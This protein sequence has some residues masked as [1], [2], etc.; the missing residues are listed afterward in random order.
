MGFNIESALIGAGVLFA[1]AVS[2]AKFTGYLDE[3]ENN[4]A[5]KMKDYV[6]EKLHEYTRSR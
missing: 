1:V 3:R 6:D 5:S 2:I 4:A